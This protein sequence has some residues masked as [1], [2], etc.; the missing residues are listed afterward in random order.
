MEISISIAG[1]LTLWVVREI[2]GFIL[3]TKLEPHKQTVNRLMNKKLLF[4]VVDVLIL[5]YSFWYAFFLLNS[6]EVATKRDVLIGFGLSLFVTV[7]VMNLFDDLVQWA[8][9]YKELSQEHAEKLPIL[10]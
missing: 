3:K 9:R 2:A 5:C 6:I 7:Q 10:G 4:V 8:R 1:V